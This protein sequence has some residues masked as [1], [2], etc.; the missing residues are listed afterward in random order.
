MA[1]ETFER[2]MR[3]KMGE[4]YS[5]EGKSHVETEIV[6]P[7]KEDYSLLMIIWPELHKASSESL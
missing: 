6:L 2:V 5:G 7:D 3:E 4:L 1:E